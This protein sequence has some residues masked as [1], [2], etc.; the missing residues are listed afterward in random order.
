MQLE[1]AACQISRGTC[2]CVA[3]VITRLHP[4]A[5]KLYLNRPQS[6]IRRL[7]QVTDDLPPSRRRPHENP[8]RTSHRTE[9]A[10]E[11]R[12]TGSGGHVPR[13]D[14]PITERSISVE[15]VDREESV[16]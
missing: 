6:Q 15:T 1:T 11:D 12:Q 10:E 14:Q 5:R 13:T 4:N 3:A 9:S 7:H 16:C 8:V 2:D